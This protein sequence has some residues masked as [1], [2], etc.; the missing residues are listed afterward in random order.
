MIELE[1]QDF[2]Q[3]KWKKFLKCVCIVHLKAKEGKGQV[4]WAL[5]HKGS[6]GQELQVCFCLFLLFSH[7]EGWEAAGGSIGATLC[8][9]R[10]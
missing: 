2:F 7:Q 5:I 4:A 9:V 8:E 1:E 6:P 10:D 3:Q